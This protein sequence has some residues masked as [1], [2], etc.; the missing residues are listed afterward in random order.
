[1][2]VRINPLRCNGCGRA[3]EPGCVL[4]CPGDLLYKD[5]ANKCAIR[6]P[7]DCW[8]CAACLKECPKQAI[9]MYLPVQI[10]GRGSTLQAKRRKNGINWLLT[11]PDGTEETFE[12]IT[13]KV[14]ERDK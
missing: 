8:D 5:S 12:I 4:V 10:G 3:A 7:R 14:E 6:E 11:K 2:T 1:M 9:E 13:V